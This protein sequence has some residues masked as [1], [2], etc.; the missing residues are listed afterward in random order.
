[1]ASSSAATSWHV[2]SRCIAVY[3]QSPAVILT[4]PAISA[5]LHTFRG[6]VPVHLTALLMCLMLSALQG[7]QVFNWQ[8][9][10]VPWDVP[11]DGKTTAATMAVWTLSFAGTAFLLM[12]LA[13]TR[14]VGMPLY[15][16]S[17]A[18]QA[19]FALWI[20][21]VELVVTFAIIGPVAAK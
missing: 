17:A 8:A 20:E 19:D 5:Q 1:V 16:L 2:R 7:W 10:Q 21:I 4:K 12:P 3:K 18:G 6:A 13:Y 14:I 15:Q 11:W 9:Y